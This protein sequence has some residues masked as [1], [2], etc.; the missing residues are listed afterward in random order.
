MAVNSV[1]NNPVQP[2][3]DWPHCESANGI[4]PHFYEFTI[5]LVAGKSILYCKQCGDVIEVAQASVPGAAPTQPANAPNAP[6]QKP[7]P[8]LFP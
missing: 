1:V 5:D 4:A 2:P 3:D 7:S 8:N 6:A